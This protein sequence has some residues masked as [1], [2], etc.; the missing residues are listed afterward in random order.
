MT[1]RGSPDVSTQDSIKLLDLIGLHEPI[2]DELMNAIEKVVD[3]GSY[4]L[5]E[6]VEAFESE[7]VEYTG[8]HHAVGCGSGSDALLLALQ[9]ANV[10]AGDEVI[11]PAYSFFATAGAIARLG[12]SPVFVDIEPD[13]LNLNPDLVQRTVGECQRLRALLPVDIFGRIA[14]MKS[15]TDL[16]AEIGIPVIE[17]AAQ[18]LGARDEDQK[19]AGTRGQMG[20]ISFYPTK[21]LGAMGEGGVILTS[22]AET[23]SRLRALRSHGQ[24]HP[25]HFSELGIN[26]RLDALQAAILRVKLRRL[27]EWLAA[28][29]EVAASYDR[30]FSQAGALS[31]DRNLY[32]AEIPVLYPARPTEP[33]RSAHHQY[34][35]R[36]APELREALRLRLTFHG[37]ETGVYYPMG[38]HEQPALSKLGRCPLPLPETETATRQVLSLPC[39]PGVNESARER[40]AQTIVDEIKALSAN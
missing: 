33:A 15:L 7:L 21:N 8:A 11:C 9:A 37:I 5:G 10:G 34:T 26:S 39:H 19:A 20:C 25:N 1:C 36:V 18:A 38:L 13:S 22:D 27:P 32:E 14:S 31:S 12:A 24:T 3:G 4:A 2:R 40:V 16:G 23:A 35:I 28:R 17:D 30:L 29:E 6:E